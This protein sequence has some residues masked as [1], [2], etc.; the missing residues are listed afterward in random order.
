[1]SAR[2]E[3]GPPRAGWDDAATLTQVVAAAFHGLAPSIW[4][5][6]D[7]AERREV[8]VPYFRIFV[9]MALANGIVF[10]NPDRTA[11]ALWLPVQPG[12]DELDSGYDDRLAAAV[13]PRNIERFRRFDELLAVNHPAHAAHHHLAML[14]VAPHA[15]RR[16]IG[17]ELLTGSHEFLDRENSPAYLEASDA[18]TRGLYLRH[19]YADVGDPIEFPD[20]PCMYPMW[21]PAGG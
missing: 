11:A 15:Q 8:F 14:A 16:G 21:R 20:G 13:G 2:P 12:H 1:M 18:G 7:P 10:T 9:E 17:T 4:L 3:L 19:G 5:I 6:S